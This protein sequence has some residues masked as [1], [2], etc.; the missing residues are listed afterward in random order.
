MKQNI[1]MELLEEGTAAKL[2]PRDQWPVSL[3]AF[4]TR[5]AETVTFAT[6][7]EA[8]LHMEIG[9]S[10]ECCFSPQPCVER[11]LTLVPRNPFPSHLGV[12]R[13]HT[14][15][16]G[17]RPGGR[18]LDCPRRPTG[19]CDG[20]RGAP[21][22]RPSAP[23][24]SGRPGLRHAEWG[25]ELRVRLLRAVLRLPQPLVPP[26]SSSSLSLPPLPTQASARL[27]CLLPGLG[28]RLLRAPGCAPSRRSAG[29][30]RPWV[31]SRGK[32]EVQ[33]RAAEAMPDSPDVTEASGK[34]SQF[35]HPV[36][37]FW[38][39]SKCYDYLYQEAEVLLKNLSIQATISF[40]EDS[41]SEDEIEELTCEN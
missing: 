14:R 23:A 20:D 10:G 38:P 21:S 29:F 27:V 7:Q 36:R 33:H 11:R 1:H 40:Y 22:L 32:K 4:R 39:K 31:D 18:G 19:P 28:S 30:W 9:C 25:R 3:L 41:D 5:A 26:A 15:T 17:L 6:G 34:L 16:S 13:V 12:A 37:L 24:A 2:L 35:R 8:P